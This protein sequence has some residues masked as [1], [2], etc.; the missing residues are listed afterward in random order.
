MAKQAKSN[1]LDLFT[2]IYGVG[3][4]IVIVGAMFKFLAWPYADV[5]FIVGLS[6]E[7]LVFLF[8]GFEFRKEAP[9]RLKW[10]RVFPQIDPTFNGEYEQIDL[11]RLHEIYFKNTKAV[12]DSVESLNANLSKLN[13][14]TETIAN[15]VEKL[16]ANL[17][18]IDGATSRYENELNDLSAKMQEL[19]GFY[20]NMKLVGTKA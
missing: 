15:S 13:S 12:I 4:A 9:Q 18:K 6:T 14:A 16:G 8:S 7:A 1:R 3:A 11:S 5:L 2:L 19:N 17:E 10:E 20:N